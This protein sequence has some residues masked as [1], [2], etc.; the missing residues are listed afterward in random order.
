M[1]LVCHMIS[2]VIKGSC[3][4]SLSRDLGVMTSSAPAPLVSFELNLVD[5]PACQI[6]WS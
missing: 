6:Y 1:V 5:V 4:F 2:Q 3:D